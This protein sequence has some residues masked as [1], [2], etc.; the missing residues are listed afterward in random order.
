MG[1]PKKSHG[2]RPRGIIIAALLILAA[3]G[4]GCTQRNAYVPPPPPE[5]VVAT[6]EQRTITLYHEYTGNTAASAAVQIR[7]R[8]SGYLEKMAFRTVKRSR[9]TNCCLS[10][11]GG[12]MPPPWPT[13][14]CFWKAARQPSSNKS[15]SINGMSP[16][17]PLTPSRQN[18]RTSTK[19]T[20]WSPRPVWGRRKPRW[21]R[22]N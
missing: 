10:L 21:S 20:S 14:R 4:G 15:R 18:R 3:F 9:R 8:V 13:P 7:A 22:P 12:L 11:T 16:Y 5:V 19:A 17:F 2:M 6:A 1:K